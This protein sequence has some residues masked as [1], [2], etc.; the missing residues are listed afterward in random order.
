M[1]KIAA[2]DSD[3]IWN[4]VAL[5]TWI[6]DITLNVDVETPV[7]TGLGDAG[8][9]RTVGNYDYNFSLAGPWDGAS[10]AL[11]VTLLKDILAG[12]VQKAQYEVTGTAAGATTPVY[13]SAASG[14]YGSRFSISSRVG[15]GV[16]YTAEI[17]GNSALTRATS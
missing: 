10:S 11:D 1:A 3:F 8:P 17:V 7:V 16:A 6:N 14:A 15:E 9:R 5:E 4:S 2:K 13:E 12:T